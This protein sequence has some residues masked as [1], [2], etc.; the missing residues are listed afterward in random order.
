[1]NLATFMIKVEKLS[2]AIA[3]FVVIENAIIVTGIATPP[4]P[5]PA[6]L[7]KAYKNTKIQRPIISWL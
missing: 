3:S 4:L 7:L 2:T 1:M 5:P 6:T